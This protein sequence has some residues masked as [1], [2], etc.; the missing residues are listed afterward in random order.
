MKVINWAGVYLPPIIRIPRQHS[1]LAGA[2]LPDDFDVF[3][4]RTDYAILMEC[5]WFT[6]PHRIHGIFH[7]Q[8]PNQLFFCGYKCQECGEIYLTPDSVK[9]EAGLLD[10]MNHKCME[11]TTR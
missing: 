11:P 1:P 2:T 6:T 3:Q 10:A 9:D 5:V 8:S 7:Y 4:V